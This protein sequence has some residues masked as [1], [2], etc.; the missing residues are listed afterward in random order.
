MGFCKMSTSFEAGWIIQCL[1]HEVAVL[2]FI[3]CD[4]LSYIYSI[5]TIDETIERRE[6]LTY[7]RLAPN[8]VLLVN[9]LDESIVLRNLF[10][11]NPYDTNDPRTC[12]QVIMRDFNT[13]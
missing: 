13:W 1:G 2:R 8:N 7:E 9:R 6:Y 3:G 5:S 11:I 10:W 4:H 12:T